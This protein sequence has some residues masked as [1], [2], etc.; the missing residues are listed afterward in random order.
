MLYIE[1]HQRLQPSSALSR[2]TLLAPP[3][4]P[5]CILK[6]TLLYIRSDAGISLS[7]LQ[8]PA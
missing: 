6:T 2:I 3:S 1:R 8:L 4:A 5:P 7:L